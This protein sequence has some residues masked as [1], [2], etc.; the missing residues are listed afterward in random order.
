MA[1]GNER[2]MCHGGK[3]RRGGDKGEGEKKSPK[4]SFFLL[5]SY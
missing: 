5:F 4:T 2:A 1:S 3:K